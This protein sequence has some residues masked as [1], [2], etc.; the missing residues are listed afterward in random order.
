MSRLNDNLDEIEAL[1]ALHDSLCNDP[2]G[3]RCNFHCDAD[4]IIRFLPALVE[5]A[6]AAQLK[7]N[8]SFSSDKQF[9]GDWV[10]VPL[11][12]FMALRASLAKLEPK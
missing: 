11:E 1:I 4:D 2:P 3:T 7:R 12:D 10:C 5:I 6:R 9:I 8:T